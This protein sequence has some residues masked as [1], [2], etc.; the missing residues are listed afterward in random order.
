MEVAHASINF[1][2]GLGGIIVTITTNG[3]L[4][5]I[6]PAQNRVWLSFP[7]VG[8]GQTGMRI[9]DVRENARE[10]LRTIFVGDS[11][12]LYARSDHGKGYL[13]TKLEEDAILART[14]SVLH[15]EEDLVALLINLLPQTLVSDPYPDA[16]DMEFTRQGARS[17]LSGVLDPRVIWRIP[18]D[19][20]LP[21]LVWKMVRPTN[22]W[23]DQGFG[24]SFLGRLDSAFKE[25]EVNLGN[26]LFVE[27]SPKIGFC[28]LK[29]FV[30]ERH[31][32][33]YI[34]MRLFFEY[35]QPED[36]PGAKV[37]KTLEDATHRIRDNIRDNAGIATRDEI[38]IDEEAR[39]V[40]FTTF[41]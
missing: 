41:M 9:L 31:G 15:G 17:A 30:F 37:A 18:E 27:D 33:R 23:C 4:R 6:R 8:A 19:R 36:K 35:V 34:G 22:K 7:F 10:H 32:E 38:T 12:S 40:F 1:D 21:Y 24:F 20:Y 29:K 5:E 28:F 26:P 14:S 39:T 25:L 13:W 16:F 11:E 2:F 3:R